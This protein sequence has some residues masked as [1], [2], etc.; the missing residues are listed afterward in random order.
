MALRV[1]N[2][3]V[4]FGVIAIFGLLQKISSNVEN[5]VRETK[6][7]TLVPKRFARKSSFCSKINPSTN[8]VVDCKE[9]QNALSCLE[10][11]GEKILEN[12]PN[13]IKQWNKYNEFVLVS[14]SFL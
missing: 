7:T 14:Y 9:L 6:P 2:L 10:S 8:S 3:F 13:P 5:D 12:E 1:K 11:E 4:I